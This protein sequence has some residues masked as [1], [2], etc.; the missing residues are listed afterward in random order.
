[1]INLGTVLPGS[2][3]PIPFDTFGASGESLTMTGLA[4]GDVRVYKGTSMTE[5]ASTSGFTLIDTDGIDVDALTGIHGLTIDLSDDTTAGFWQAGEWYRVV[6]SD[7]TINTQ[8]VRFTPV[9]FR[10]G[11]P[12]SLL[13]TTIAT[14]A[15]QTSFTLTAGP[16][17]N[18]ALNGMPCVIHDK[19]SGVQIA[20]GVISD[21]VG[22]TKT[23]TLAA[24]PGIFTMAAGDNISVFVGDALSPAER[25]N[26]ASAASNYSATRGLAGTALP[27]AAADAAGGLPISDAGALDLDAR[28]DAAISSRSSHS[29]ADV[30]TEVDSNSTQLAALVARLTA[31]RA[32]YLDNLNIGENVAGTS[33]VTAIQNNTRIVFTVP[34][35]IERPDSGSKTVRLWLYLYDETGNMEAPDSTPTVA[36]ANDQGTD[37]STNLGTVTNSATGVYYVDYTVADSHAIEALRFQVSVTE[38]GATILKGA[39]AHVVDTTA[40]DFTSADRAKLDELHDNRLTSARA[41]YLD[42]LNGHTPQTGDSFARLGAPAGASVSADIAA[43]QTDL[44]AVIAAIAALNDLDAAAVRAAVGMGAANLDTQLSTIDTVVAAINVITAALGATAAARLALS[45]A[46]MIPGT[47]DTAT[48]GHT[49][50]TTEFQADDVTEATADHYNGRI[51]IFTSGALAGQATDITDYAAVGGIGQFTV[52]AL[53]EAPANDDTFI[54]V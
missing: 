41:G 46:Q 12:G 27:P 23:V 2:T 39:A 16:A 4:V 20:K 6:I 47:V 7:I 24:D 51:V 21:Y 10:I 17:D 31:A 9:I 32:G 5:R 48:N 35:I 15:S 49:P 8:T 36:A 1:M 37:R 3:V 42:N 19:A 34:Q 52:T 13:D 45:A 14:L 18:D 50:T 11:Y 38:G 54:I 40:V 53:T 22:S 25:A 44:D 43:N 26:L 33:E 29:A 28:L 30:R